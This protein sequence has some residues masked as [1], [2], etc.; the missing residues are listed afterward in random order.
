KIDVTEA[1]RRVEAAKERG[2]LAR[3]AA[4]W[5][6]EKKLPAPAWAGSKK[7]KLDADTLRFLL[8]RQTRRTE[9]EID[10]EARDVFD[11]V[12]RESAGP[13]AEKLLAL[14]M[15]NGGPSA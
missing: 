1:G 2:K 14:V 6:D 12:D 15:K 3:P 8:H 4:K 5:V 10:P 13:L 7:K 11:L 9:I